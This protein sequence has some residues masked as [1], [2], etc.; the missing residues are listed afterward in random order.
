M[1]IPG[2]VA[3]VTGG[4]SGMGEV[5]CRYLAEQGAKV[6]II[7]KS[8]NAALRVA[9]EIQGIAIGCDVT[10]AAP[11]EAA[12]TSIE[13]QYE[14]AIAIVVNCAGVAPAKRMVG[15]EGPVSL[16]WFEEVIQIN[17]IGTFNVMRLAADQMIKAQAMDDNERGIIINT[18]SIAAFEGQIGQTAYSASKA[19]IVGMMLPAA[20]ELAQFGIRVMTIAPGLVDTPMLQGMPDKVRDSLASQSLF[21][22]RFVKPAEFAALVGHVISN[23]MLNAEVIRLDAGIRMQAT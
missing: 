3:V 7:D 11:L 14:Q 16:A 18:A 2:K 17:L 19:G 20:R 10:Q 4:G 22:K 9:K 5:V 15:K 1:K 21:P 6:V 23:P 8:E 12:F 13:Q